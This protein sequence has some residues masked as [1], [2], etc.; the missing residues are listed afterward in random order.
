MLKHK[1]PG[2]NVSAFLKLVE[3]Q[4][5]PDGSVPAPIPSD[6]RERV[7]E[8]HQYCILDTG[9]DARFDRITRLAAKL[10]D[11]P[12]VLLTLVDEAREWFK[13]TVG[14]DITEISRDHGFCSHTILMQERSSM[15]IVDTL[16]DRRFATHPFVVNAPNLRFY[17]G[18]PL[19]TA[20]GRKIGT[21]CVHDVKPRPDFNAKSVQLLGELADIV[22][23][24]IEFFRLENERVLLVRELSHR[25]KNCFAMVASVASL[26]SRGHTEVGE[27]IKDFGA[28]LSAMAKAHDTLVLQNWDAV[29]IRD[30]ADG[31]L[32]GH[33]SE[34]KDRIQIDLPNT[35]IDSRSAQ[36]LALLLHELVTNAIKHGAL[37]QPGG[38]VTVTGHNDRLSEEIVNFEWRETGGPP[39]SAPTRSGFGTTVINGSIRQTGGKVEFDWRTEGLICRFDLRTEPTQRASPVPPRTEPPSSRQ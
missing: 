11:V 26:S 9:K 36:T 38:R 27:F 10:L 28:R 8:L 4:R 33:Q 34:A 7:L 23:D 24:E 30:L 32:S 20:S 16:Q 29:G 5:Q 15:V 18:A 35:L 14:T 1:C 17:A 12:I 37:T 25:V 6:D 31:V 19:M 13:S 2:A 21:L 3:L 22:M 39:V